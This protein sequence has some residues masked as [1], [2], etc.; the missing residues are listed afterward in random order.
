MKRDDYYEE[1]GLDRIIS[2]SD[3]VFAFSLTLLTVDLVVP[4]LQGSQASLLVQDLL[5]EFSRF[6]YFVLT[7]FITGSYWLAHHRIYR[8]IV[9]YDS[10]LMRVNLYFLLFITLMPFTTKLLSEYGHVQAVVV[11]AAVLY[12][13]PGFLLGI[14]W[15]YASRDHLLISGKVPHD[16]A[17]MTRMKNYVKPTVF[18]LSI[19]FSFIH[20]A[21]TLYFWIILFPIG[22]IMDH[23]YPEINEDD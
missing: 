20:P 23:L 19:P 3:A 16:F 9:R 5:G 22:I 17:R 14:I 11:S 12:A 10:I 6:L 4:E 15:H 21:Y 13:A 18:I 1:R 2:I 8:F 7:F